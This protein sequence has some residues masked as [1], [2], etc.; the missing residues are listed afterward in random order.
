MWWLSVCMAAC[1]GM[2]ICVYTCSYMCACIYR[3]HCHMSCSILITLFSEVASLTEPRIHRFGKVAW[4]VSPRDSPLSVSPALG[5]HTYTH[6]VWHLVC[7]MH[8]S[9]TCLSH[10][11][12]K[13]HTEAVRYFQTWT[14]NSGRRSRNCR[15]LAQGLTAGR[16]FRERGTDSPQGGLCLLVMGATHKSYVWE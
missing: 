8:P 11:V 16:R 15:Q 12:H 3:S 14:P 13:Q 1:A 7:Y 6:T 4:P 10:P 5:S 2:C 9:L